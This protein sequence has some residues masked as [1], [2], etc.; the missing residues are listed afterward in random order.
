MSCP[1]ARIP[2]VASPR[3]ALPQVSF[4]RP[5]HLIDVSDLPEALARQEVSGYGLVDEGFKL[6]VVLRLPEPVEQAQV[7]AGGPRAGGRAGG[8][9]RC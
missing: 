1:P 4:S 7:R 2:S 9:Q 6:T 8:R 3:P 5:A